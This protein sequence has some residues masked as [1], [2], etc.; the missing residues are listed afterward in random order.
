MLAQPVQVGGSGSSVVRAA[1][2]P[3]CGPDRYHSKV[4]LPGSAHESE[5]SLVP[6][7]RLGNGEAVYVGVLHRHRGPG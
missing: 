4:G 3:R 6:T 1:G 2:H 5:I 7:S